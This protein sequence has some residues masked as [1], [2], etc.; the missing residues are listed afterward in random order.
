MAT[1][2]YLGNPKLKA[3]NVPVEFT[4]EQLKE[5]VKCSKNP[6]YFVE[7]YVYIVHVDKGLMKFDMY[8]FQKKMVQ[9]FN[10]DRFVICKLPRQSGKSTTIISYLLHYILYNENV[11]VGI[12]ANKGQLARELLDRLKLAYENLPQWLQQGVVTWNKGNIELENGSK[13][14]AVATSSSA[15]RG[16]SFNIIFLD[17]FAH[18]PNQ[19][20]EDF[21]SSVYPTITSGTST[22]V[23]I[24]STPLGLNMYYKMWMD[25]IEKRSNYTPIEVHWSE[26]PGRDDKWKQ[27]TIRNTSE[28][29]FN[30]EFGCEFVGSTNTLIAGSKLRTMGFVNPIFSNKNLD[31]HEYPI[32]KHSYVIVVDTSRG[33]GLDYSA[34]TVIDATTVP[35]KVVAKFKDNEISPMLYPSIINETAKKYNNAFVLIEI[36]DIGAQV[37]DIMHQDLE[38]ENLLMM[39]WKGRAGQQLGTG[40][41]KNGQMGIR[42]TKQVKRIGCNALKNLIE[43]NK[44]IINDYDIIYELTTFSQSKDS[45]QAEEGHHDDLVITLV[46]FAWLTQQ[47]YFKDLTEVDLREKMYAEKIKEVEDEMLPFGFLNDGLDDENFVDREGNYW[48]VDANN[49]VLF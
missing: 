37:A 40:F 49:F 4:E 16:S 45:Y 42:T 35:Y 24:V 1:G 14:M 38:Y 3:A 30:Q 19:L 29:Q 22:K 41:G 27:E 25:A 48:H 12:L 23:F 43:E 33:K 7:K 6:L 39:S 15:V 34:F 28:Q 11:N 21:F 10:D 46:I 17:E 5:Y 32:E 26:V 8:P 20:A 36:N 9:T 18:I 47:R 44:L 2:H 31:V 13:I